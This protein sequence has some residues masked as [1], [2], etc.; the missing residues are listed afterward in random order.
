MAQFTNQASISYN[1]VTAASNI[2]T[3]EITQVL[4]ANKTAV[5]GS[6]RRGDVI[7]YA[8]ALTNSGANELTGLTVSDNLGSY[9]V[10]S[11]TAVPLT[12]TGDGVL[13]YTNGTLQA[14]PTVTAGPPMAISGISVPAGGNALLIY[15]A[16]VNEYASPTS[17]STIE[18]TAT[19][20]G[21]ALTEA[22]TAAQSVAADSTAL[23]QIIKAV[24]PTTVAEDGELT[25]TF[26]IE[27]T[28]GEAADTDAALTVTDTFN[29]PLRGT[30]TVTLNGA[31]LAVTGNY[32]YDA[33]TGVFSTTAGAITVPAATFAQD[34]T[35]GEWTVT[36]GVATLTVTG[37]L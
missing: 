20:S 3:G 11:S 5:S 6:Y 12:Y 23:L 9:T 30:V 31:P 36:P 7:T 24:S 22:V 28:G 15:T 29:P 32:S 10:G 25:Y 16:R 27:N 17:G 18:N 34:S 19:V 14:S 13:Y 33:A 37:T 1:G 2:V 35:T 21:G 4:S 26:T 8:V